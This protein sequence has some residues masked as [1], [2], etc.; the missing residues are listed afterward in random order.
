LLFLFNFL[1]PAAKQTWRT[2]KAFK[3]AQQQL[4]RQLFSTNK[5]I[6]GRG[7]NLLAAS[8]EWPE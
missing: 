2:Q 5:T 1:S 4:D 8:G 3:R 7:I 6:I